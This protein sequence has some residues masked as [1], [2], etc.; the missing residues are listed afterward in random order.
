MALRVVQNCQITLDNV[1]VG[2][3]QRLPKAT[4]FQAGTNRVLESSRAF[5][6]WVAA[7]I[8]LGV[9]DNAIKYTTARKQFGRPIAGTSSLI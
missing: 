2:E 6:C 5:V 1:E 8:C 4:N 3:S 7:G 9:Y